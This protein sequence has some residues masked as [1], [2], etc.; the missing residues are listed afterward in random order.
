MKRLLQIVLLAC[1]LPLSA[2]SSGAE[3]Q[4][5]A[6]RV[7]D[8]ESTDDPI[9]KYATDVLRL[10]LKKSGSN[11]QLQKQSKNRPPQVRVIEELSH[12]QGEVDVMWTITSKER[13]QQLLPIRIPID[14]GLMGWRISFIRDG[15][16]ASFDKLSSLTDLS[17]LRGGQGYFWP[18]TNILQNNG[19]QVVT[20]TASALPSM[21]EQTRFDYFPRSIIEIWNEQ[22]NFANYKI[23]VEQSFVLRY[24][25]AM[26][27]FVAPDNRELAAV[28]ERGLERAIQDGSFDTLF[29]TYCRPFLQKAKLHRRRI[30]E[31]KNPLLPQSMLPLDRPELW[32][33]EADI[34]NASR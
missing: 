28:I 11:Y 34:A 12:G 22:S 30:L 21:L 1:L 27:F 5:R 25:A 24:P 23:A 31:L 20:G 32:I 29:K 16:Q 13:E 4:Q 19:L 33:S 6:V 7:L 15:E 10:A 9:A 2:L 3:T 26:Y 18:D 8:L 14:K 17:K